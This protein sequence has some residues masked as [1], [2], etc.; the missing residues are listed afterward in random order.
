MRFTIVDL[1]NELTRLTV[2]QR[3]QSPDTFKHKNIAFLVFSSA[4]Y[5]LNTGTSIREISWSNGLHCDPN[6][7]K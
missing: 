3:I 4:N 2:K 5:T 1:T 7:S 6:E